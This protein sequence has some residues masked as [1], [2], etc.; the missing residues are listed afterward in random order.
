MRKINVA[1]FGGGERALALFKRIINIWNNKIKI[2]YAVFM[3][4]YEHEHIFCD[5][6]EILAKKFNIDYLVSDI[7]TDEI[8]DKIKYYNPIVAIGGEFGVV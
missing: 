6:L 8:I 3:K 7:I 5:E 1:F 4:G 2:D